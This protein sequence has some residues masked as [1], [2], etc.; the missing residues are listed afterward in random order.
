MTST[1]SPK[2]M[3]HNTAHKNQ[4]HHP[5]HSTQLTQK[6]NNNKNKVAYEQCS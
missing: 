2:F 5:S 3:K 6:Q 1:Y 4:V